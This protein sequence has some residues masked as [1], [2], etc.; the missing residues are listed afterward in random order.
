MIKWDTKALAGEPLAFGDG[1]F[2]FAGGDHDGI[3]VDPSRDPL[4]KNYP[5]KVISD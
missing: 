5:E 3:R 1:E 4:R 2:D